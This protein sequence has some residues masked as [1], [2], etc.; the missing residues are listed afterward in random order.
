MQRRRSTRCLK[1]GNSVSVSALAFIIRLPIEG[2]AAQ[3]GI[4]PQCITLYSLPTLCRT[5]TG[6]VGDICS[7]AM[8]KRGLYFWQVAVKVPAN[9]DVTKLE[10]RCDA[11][12][13]NFVTL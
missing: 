13:H 10:C 7:G 6:I 11:A 9:P 1:E 8:L 3:F 12:A 5:I 2:S 4:N